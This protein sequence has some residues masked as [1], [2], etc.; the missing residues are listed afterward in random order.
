MSTANALF[1]DR[2]LEARESSALQT[3]LRRVRS[4]RASPGNGSPDRRVTGSRPTG[5]LRSRP[6][7]TRAQRSTP[8]SARQTKFGLLFWNP[9]TRFVRRTFSVS[10]SSP[11]TRTRTT[12]HSNE[13]VRLST[14]R[15][16]LHGFDSFVSSNHRDVGTAP[17]RSSGRRARKPGIS[18][19]SSHVKRKACTIGTW[20]TDFCGSLDRR[21]HD[22]Q[23]GRGGSRYT[24]RVQSDEAGRE[25]RE[26]TSRLICTNR[27]P[28][29]TK[30][31]CRRPKFLTLNKR[32]REKTKIGIQHV[33]L[34]HFLH[35]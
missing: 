2:P 21:I 15:T 16:A 13:N 33:Y 20:N 25:L 17:S 7:R 8:S 5:S 10:A 9:S 24:R 31:F 35:P 11:V 19:H 23:I 28:S 6:T 4:G 18:S 27:A 12:L 34:N 22:V 14:R 3:T 1:V 26:A 32:A 30:D 29:G